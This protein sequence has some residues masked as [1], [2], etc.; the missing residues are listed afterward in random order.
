MAGDIT[1][2]NARRVALIQFDARPEAVEEN[3]AKMSS[4][5]GAASREGARW[6]MFHEGTTCDYTPRL[7]ELAEAVPDGPSTQLMSRL[8]Q[9]HE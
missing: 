3:L 4:L 7:A 9:E 2:M 1:D 8:A 6:I 5:L